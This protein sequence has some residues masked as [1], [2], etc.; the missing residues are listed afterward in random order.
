MEAEVPGPGVEHQGEPQGGPEVGPS[1]LRQDLAG[2]LEQ[3]AIDLHW[4]AHGHGLQLRGE[5]EHQVEVGHR[6]DALG[7]GIDPLL[8]GCGLALG[9]VTVPATVVDR[10]LPTAAGTYLDMAAEGGCATP[11]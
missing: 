10:M 8:L 6:Q 4:M 3:G 2:D 9:A 5:R 7:P 1:Q 11:G